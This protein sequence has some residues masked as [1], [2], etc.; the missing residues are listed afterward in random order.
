M[1]CGCETKGGKKKRTKLV[2][3]K[4]RI[5]ARKDTQKE[6]FE[7]EIPKMIMPDTVVNMPTR[8]GIKGIKL[9]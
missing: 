3:P 1:G 9:M 4:V 6:P 7:Y 5:T 2:L 8:K